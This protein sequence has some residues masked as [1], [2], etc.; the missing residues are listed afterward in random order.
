[1]RET[2]TLPTLSDTMKTGRLV[3][4]LKQVGDPVKKGDVLAEV[5]TDKAIMDVEAFQKGYLSGPLAQTD[6][7]IPVGTVIGYISDTPQQPQDAETRVPEK[8][9]V[10]M[11]APADNARTKAHKED[12]HSS[13]TLN[14]V[15]TKPDRHATHPASPADIPAQT[16]V[17]QQGVKASPYAR[18]LARELGIQLNQVNAASDGVIYAS[19]VLSTALADPPPDLDSG[20]AYHYEPYT[21][22]HR[23]VANNM[24][25]TLGIPT[26]RVNA[27]LPL[28]P[29][30]KMAH[31]H[32]QS[33]TLLLARVCA[34]CVEEHPRFNAV[35]TRHGLAM[36][37]QVDVGIAVDVPGGLLTPVLR[38]AAQRPLDELGEDWR[39]LRDKVERMRLAPDDY[40]GATFYL[41]N[42]GVFEQVTHFDALVPP[43]AAA[44][45]SL[46]SATE[47]DGKAEFT[48]SCDHRVVFGADAARF[49]ETLS[50]Y[51][52]TPEN[53]A[54]LT[55]SSAQSQSKG[56]KL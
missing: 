29:L 47:A 54:A 56:K 25:A 9:S 26:F 36:R 15:T 52:S 41:S 1:M 30:K 31:E 24:I 14:A 6:A 11:G 55:I 4:W 20:P 2:I 17:S 10:A 23:A 50:G 37:E 39:I 3:Q 16:P 43:G 45:I 42:L 28:A 13:T 12:E 44:I 5:E 53:M 51:L 21:S 18:G 48:L 7:D 33:L 8:T 35:Y 22:M 46:G 40:Q 38:D 34:L 19:Q 27:R 32:K 49:L